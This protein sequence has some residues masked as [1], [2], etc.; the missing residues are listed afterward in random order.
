VQV[1]TLAGY[2]TNLA[3]D[4][5]A[6]IDFREWLGG[7]HKIIEYT[8]GLA[9]AGG[10]HLAER[11]GTSVMDPDGELTLNMVG[12]QRVIPRHSFNVLI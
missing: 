1:N 4:V 5:R 2:S 7:E 6:A 9:I 11:L 3:P 10:K 8:H 12:G